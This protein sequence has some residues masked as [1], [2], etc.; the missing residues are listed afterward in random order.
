MPS[1]EEKGIYA[2][3]I[4][5]AS[6]LPDFTR[7]SKKGK[8]NQRSCAAMSARGYSCTLA[9]GHPLWCPHMAG[10]ASGVVAIWYSE[11]AI[12]K[13]RKQVK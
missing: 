8:K 3:G 2:D 13:M 7:V 6:G 9:E 1:N 12:D 10:A 5:S 4:F 11:L